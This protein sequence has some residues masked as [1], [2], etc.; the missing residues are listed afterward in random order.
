MGD[1]I[2]GGLLAL[3]ATGA[4]WQSYTFATSFLHAISP[5]TFPRLVSVPLGLLSLYLIF[6]PEISERWP[7]RMALLRQL[8]L[9]LL[10]GIYA[11]LLKDLGFIPI[12]LPT[13]VLLIRLFGGNWKQALF[14]SIL[15]T[16][17]LYVL[18]EFA[19]DIPLPA[20]PI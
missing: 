19:L 14:G 5:G 4:W 10:L 16:V 17:I 12:T 8:S 7:N 9:I 11:T 15:L 3:L 2:A 20:I 1:R 6:R 13:T 18:F